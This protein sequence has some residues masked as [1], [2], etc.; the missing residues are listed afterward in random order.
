MQQAELPLSDNVI[1]T[2][3]VIVGAGP[4]GLFQVFELGLLGIKAHVLDSLKQPGGQCSELYPEKPIYDIPALP[5]CG[6]QELVDRLLQQIKPF[7][8]EFHYGEEAVELA[9]KGDGRFRLR[10]SAGT[11]FDAGAVVVAAGVGSFQP[12][13]LG[14]EGIESFEGKQIHYK[15]TSSSAFHGKRLAVFGGGDSPLACA[16]ALAV[17]DVIA[18]ERLCERAEHIGRMLRTRLAVLQ[19]RFP[20]I[21]DVRGLGAMVAMELVKQRDARQPDAELT[22]ALVQAAAK[23]GLVILSCGVYANVIRFLAPLTISDALLAEGLDCLEA[24]LGDVLGAAR[25]AV[26]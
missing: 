19:Q 9:R 10:T 25:T 14:V 21:G 16:A 22:R 26:A 23:R 17:L 1:S 20:A 15:V 8:A 13:R 2:E 7:G 6:A 4:A 3:V 24:A 18:E 12:R 5:L 11:E